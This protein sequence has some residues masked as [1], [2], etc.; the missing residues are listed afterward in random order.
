MKN[1][2]VYKMEMKDNKIYATIFNP[3]HTDVSSIMVYNTLN[4]E[5]KF[6]ESFDFPLESNKKIQIR[7]VGGQ[8][9]QKY[10]TS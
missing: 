1:R 9:V 4:G 8:M 5:Y 3:I 6:V 2:T 10:R 7:R